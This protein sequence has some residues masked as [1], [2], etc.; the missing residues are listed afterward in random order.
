[1]PVSEMMDARSSLLPVLLM[2]LSCAM[3]VQITYMNVKN[4]KRRINKTRKPVKIASYYN[5]TYREYRMCTSVNIH[6]EIYNI[7]SIT[8]N[9]TSSTIVSRG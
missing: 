7:R 4:R 8:F 1:M 2:S 6:I 9:H 5:F 3:Q